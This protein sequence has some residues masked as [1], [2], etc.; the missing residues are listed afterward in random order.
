MDAISLLPIMLAGNAS[1]TSSL[2]TM[3]GILIMLFAKYVDNA[4][5]EKM[6]WRLHEYRTAAR[7]RFHLA[8]TVVS[9]S[10]ETSSMSTS[11]MAVAWHVHA[12]LKAADAGSPTWRNVRNI[13]ELRLH[14]RDI[15]CNV[16]TSGWIRQDDVR[17][18]FAL[19]VREIDP[20]EGSKRYG[21][22]TDTTSVERWN[23]V[24]TSDA[25]FTIDDYIRRC[26]LEFQD[27]LDADASKAVQTLHVAR[28]TNCPSG[29][30]NRFA[31][32]QFATT[33]TLANTFWPG[34]EALV[35]SFDAFLRGRD[36]YERRGKPYN[37]KRMFYGPPGGGK[38]SAIKALAN[39][40][41]RDLVVVEPGT[42]VTVHEMLES[43]C[44]YPTQNSVPYS[45]CMFVIEEFDCFEFA[46]R[47]CYDDGVDSAPT[48]SDDDK[49]A[50]R[51][52]ALAELL[53]AFDGIDEKDGFVAIFT[54]NHVEKFDP[55]LIR[56]GRLELALFDL[57]GPR[58]I[59]DYWRLHF[60][61]AVPRELAS[62][63]AGMQRILSVAQLCCMLDA[64]RDA[65]EAALHELVLSLKNATKI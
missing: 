23:I 60:D 22:S 41:G 51:R 16:F 30:T 3:L 49:R 27:H 2:L 56:P 65:A 8:G 47:R 53:T 7:M 18:E 25:F 40:C 6:L 4:A 31:S 17:V 36:E 59:A 58:E 44:T 9:G 54:T 14:K 37:W 43:I 39:H 45:K 46:D 13:K 33:K 1:E 20:E 26:E 62:A 35:A 24:L 32:K 42:F 15:V 38:T 19:F 63:M 10:D 61:A 48:K 28:P 11:F 21:R 34:K 50:E 64:G 55:A 52:V 57:L 5:M 29:G 12:S